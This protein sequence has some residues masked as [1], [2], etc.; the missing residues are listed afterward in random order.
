VER[1]GD[2]DR[3]KVVASRSA[4]CVI[5]TVVGSGWVFALDVRDLV[6]IGAWRRGIHQRVGEKRSRRGSG[7]TRTPRAAHERG[8]FRGDCARPGPPRMGERGSARGR[9]RTADGRT[10]V[11]CCT[12][13]C[14]FFSLFSC[15]RKGARTLA[16]TQKKLGF[17]VN[18]SALSC[19]TIIIYSI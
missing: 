17:Y 5:A 19:S 7:E 14:P 9:Y 12:K 8:G 18:I 2:G 13:N 16:H 10:K 1:D 11:D 4:A 6:A 15:R 3:D